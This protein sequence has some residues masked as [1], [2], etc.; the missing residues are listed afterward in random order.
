MK[1]VRLY[2]VLL[3]L[4]ILS[5]CGKTVLSIDV[6]SSVDV[7]K[8]FTILNR[9][10]S[11]LCE[12]NT[13][14]RIHTTLIILTTASYKTD[15]VRVTFYSKNNETKEYVFKTNYP[16]EFEY[17]TELFNNIKKVICTKINENDNFTISRIMA[18]GYNLSKGYTFFFS[19]G[20]QLNL[21]NSKIEGDYVNTND[22][23]LFDKNQK[24]YIDKNRESPPPKEYIEICRELRNILENDYNWLNGEW[25]VKFILTSSHEYIRN[26]H[27]PLNY[28]V[29][30]IPKSGYGDNFW[31]AFNQGK[32][33]RTMLHEVLE[34]N[35]IISCNYDYINTRF[36][37]E[38]LAE[39]I[40]E[41]I[42]EK[43]DWRAHLFLI[44]SKY[45]NL[46][47]VKKATVNL[48]K[49]KYSVPRN[50]QEYYSAAQYFWENLEDN[51]NLDIGRT[52]E[53]FRER[54][55]TSP[56]DKDEYEWNYITLLKII[57]E[58]VGMGVE[59]IENML[60]IDI[61]EVKEF[62]I[63]KYG[64]ED[65]Y[66]NMRL[67]WIRFPFERSKD[68]FFFI[69][70]YEVSLKEY[71]EFLNTLDAED[72]SR[73]YKGKEI[74]F[75]NNK[76]DVEKDMGNYPV[77]FVSYH[78]AQAYAKWAG[79]RLPTMIEWE[80][81]AGKAGNIMLMPNE[82]YSLE[83]RKRITEKVFLSLFKYPWGNEWDPKKCNWD[84][85]GQYDAYK[86]LSPIDS[87]PEGKSPYGCF[88]MV[89]N[90]WEY[91]NSENINGNIHMGGCY[92]YEKSFQTTTSKIKGLTKVDVYSCVGFRC[93]KDIDN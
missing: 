10:L 72:S 73:F 31:F 60:K 49:I 84:D 74:A 32:N 63:N 3:L 86:G 24:I 78:G 62:Y 6:K 56:L 93:V 58:Q 16:N 53:L 80:S 52:I 39:L 83:E 82:K 68:M 59:D 57:S 22:F 77:T 30:Y 23:I 5:G 20:F 25:N 1:K 29:I 90:V 47:G 38:G 48:K 17:N 9:K 21:S 85:G 54:K 18:S 87:F 35:L 14:G 75:C 33:I 7:T 43:I 15:E 91:I 28:F 44:Y 8:Y 34:S 69:D 42:I 71:C 66:E 50:R 92:K 61:A 64:F 41:K 19:P 27:F 4:V 12:N 40:S 70:K 67:I 46:K 55:K 51:H 13:K 45:E 2:L 88:N 81:A 76:W 89:G 37:R 11:K 79:K 65:R 36:I 26:H